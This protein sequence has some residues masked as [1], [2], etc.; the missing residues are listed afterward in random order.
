MQKLLIHLGQE[1]GS[2]F[3]LTGYQPYW[4]ADGYKVLHHA[5]CVQADPNLRQAV[6]LFPNNAAGAAAETKVRLV[7]I[8]EAFDQLF[9]LVEVL[10]PGY[11]T[12]QVRYVVSNV[13]LLVRAAKAMRSKLEAF[14]A[15]DIPVLDNIVSIAIPLF[16]LPLLC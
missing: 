5:H 12:K 14:A 9:A 1:D 10:S 11:W 16:A 8:F 15:P 7:E 4:L 2:G 13:S 3:V 6:K